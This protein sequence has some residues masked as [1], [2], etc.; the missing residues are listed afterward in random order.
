MNDLKE[1]LFGILIVSAI[2]AGM[3]V[4]LALFI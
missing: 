3:G 1:T 4:M 2:G